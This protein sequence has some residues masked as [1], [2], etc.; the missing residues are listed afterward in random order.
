MRTL[1]TSQDMTQWCLLHAPL[2]TPHSGRVRYAAAMHLYH[3]G[4]IS[5]ELLEGF[6]ICAKRDDEYPENFQ[7]E[8]KGQTWKT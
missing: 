3:R 5:D 8:L 1:M 7:P 2:G 4:M 6:R